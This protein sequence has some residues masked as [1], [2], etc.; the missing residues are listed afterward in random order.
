MQTSDTLPTALITLESFVMLCKHVTH[1]YTT[2]THKLI[3]RRATREDIYSV[4]LRIII[5][6]E[7]LIIELFKCLPPPI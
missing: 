1:K 7:H 6:L 5:K 4:L 3:F 2:C